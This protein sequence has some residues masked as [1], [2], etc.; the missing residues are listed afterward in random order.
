MASVDST[1]EIERIKNL[2]INFNWEIIKQ[3][4]TE[5][6]ITLKIRKSIPP[7]VKESDLSPGTD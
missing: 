5:D 3:E 4:I 2:I 7:P 1:L 6:N